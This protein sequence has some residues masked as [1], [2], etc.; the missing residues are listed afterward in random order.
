MSQIEPDDLPLLTEV[1]EE[2]DPSLPMLTNVVPEKVADDSSDLLPE[3]RNISEAEMQRLLEHFATH[4][5]SVL[6]DRVSHYLED[7]HHQAVRLAILELK[8]ELPE[9]LRQS[10]AQHDTPHPD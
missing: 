4:L 7:L 9:L 2:G 3:G 5:E 10:L 8:S 6:I 1:I